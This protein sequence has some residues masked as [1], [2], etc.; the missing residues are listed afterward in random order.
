[1][2]MGTW[3]GYRY[4]A[5]ARMNGRYSTGGK[6]CTLWRH[7]LKLLVENSQSAKI[8]AI[9]I[10]RILA[11]NRSY[12]KTILGIPSLCTFLRH[13]PVQGTKETLANIR[14]IVIGLSLAVWEFSTNCFNQWRQRV[15]IV[16]EPRSDTLFQYPCSQRYLK[17]FVWSVIKYNELD[18]NVYNLENCLVLIVMS[19]K[20]LFHI[21]DID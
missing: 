16:R 12:P 9:T 5:R 4:E 6:I 10:M 21:F 15:Q 3:I 20:N 2:S 18:I 13:N 1:M 14:I 8:M 19:Y 11:Y 17:S 7:W